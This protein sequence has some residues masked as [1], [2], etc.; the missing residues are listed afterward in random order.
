[1]ISLKENNFSTLENL[2]ATEEKDIRT[3]EVAPLLE[4]A[5]YSL[6]FHELFQK[7]LTFCHSDLGKQVLQKEKFS[8][9]VAEVKEKLAET[10]DALLVLERKGKA[11]LSGLSSL[12]P[13]F[14]R[15]RNEA[16]LSIQELYQ[17]LRFLLLT[18]R[19]LAFAS[20]SEEKAFESLQ[21]ELE[22]NRFFA[23]LK[24]LHRME[25][26]EKRLARIF[27]S[28]E[29]LADEA[30]PELFSIRKK[31]RDTQKKIKEDL[32]HLLR[33]K[34]KAL[35]ES[36]ITQRGSRYVLMVKESHRQQVPGIVHDVSSTGQ[37][38]FVEPMQSVEANNKIAGLQAEERYEIERI[39]E[40]LSAELAAHLPFFES[41]Q[42]IL[43]YADAVL[44]KAQLARQ[45][46]AV[47]VQINKEERVKLYKARHPFLDKKTLVP[48][49]LFLGESYRTLL[50]T[51]P[52]TGGKTVALKTLGLFSLMVQFGLLLP[53]SEQSEIALFDKILVDI[54]DHQNMEKNLSTFS[55]HMKNMIAFTAEATRHC[56]ILTDEIGSGTDPLEGQA[57]ARVLLD[58]WRKKGALVLATSHYRELKEYAMKTEGVE[59]A[60]CAFDE[61]ELRPRY[62]L[63]LGQ[64][65]VSYAFVISERLGLEKQLIEEAKALLSEE[66]REFEALIRDLAKEKEKFYE[67]RTQAEKAQEEAENLKTQWEKLQKEAEDKKKDLVLKLREEAREKYAEKILEMDLLL[68]ELKESQQKQA[69]KEQRNQHK[70]S[71]TQLEK[72]IGEETLS[73]FFHTQEHTKEAKI[74]QLKVGEK[75]FVPAL[76]TLVRL[77]CLPNSKGQCQVVRLDNSLKLKLDQQH[78]L[79]SE[80][81]SGPKKEKQKSLQEISDEQ[82]LKKQVYGK[83]EKVSR[84]LHAMPL[85]LM[86]LGETAHDALLLLDKH[87]DQASLV[88][89]HEIRIVHGKGT[90]VLRKAVADFLKK[91]KRVES[92]SLAPFGQGDSGAT[93][94]KLKK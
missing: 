14:A 79:S 11:P 54:G 46:N 4:G 17:F 78:L 63:H 61:K 74:L 65:G 34:S 43:A 67:A 89:L 55:S 42:S 22:D 9:E 92:F 36:I 5:Y 41:N 68:L 39:L 26:L 20:T 52:N 12:S 45:Q 15:L 16:S 80:K 84:T 35:Q 72:E 85:E 27:A 23:L 19:T 24:T 38:L 75:Y 49:D 73:S 18:H 28:P 7:L 59:N 25:S 94:A 64:M 51:G 13:F 93:I 8:A 70:Q 21:K 2:L 37:T 3:P 69:L 81:F 77:E 31:I 50:I 40:Q 53:V 30:S 86:L 1:M 82:A 6:E 58:T 90:G 29:T 76:Q 60:S 10:Y 47:R 56:L 48:I 44:A 83:K 71:L 87:I 33:S 66:D 91:D 32:E 88:G 62:T 57:L